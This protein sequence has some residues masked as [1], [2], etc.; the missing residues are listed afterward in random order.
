M[1]PHRNAQTLTMKSIEL[2]FAAPQV[3]VHRMARMAAAGSVLSA[4][5]RREFQLMGEEKVVAFTESWNAMALQ[6]IRANR[7][8]AA[9]VVLFWSPAAWGAPFARATAQLH[10]AALGVLSEGIAPMHRKATAN[11]RRLARARL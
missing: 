11:A 4:R 6:A 2:A 7:A 3:V 5:D 1:T 8:L 9:S 10:G